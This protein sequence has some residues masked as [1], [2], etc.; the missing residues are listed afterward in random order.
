MRAYQNITNNACP[1]I[2]AELLL[3]SRLNNSVRIFLCLL[4]VVMNINYAIPD[5]GCF[6]RKQN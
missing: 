2:D 3:M 6:I 1:H 5:E 4:V